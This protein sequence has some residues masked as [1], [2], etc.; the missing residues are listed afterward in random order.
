MILFFVLSKSMENMTLWLVSESC[1]NHMPPCLE[2]FVCGGLIH[3]AGVPSA[4]EIPF[5]GSEM[6]QGMRG[7]QPSKATES[8]VQGAAANGETRLG[9]VEAP[10]HPKRSAHGQPTTGGQSLP[11]STMFNFPQDN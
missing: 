6:P 4:Q 7:A 8:R 10:L 1:K 5:G 9:Q 11:R 2:D 3:T